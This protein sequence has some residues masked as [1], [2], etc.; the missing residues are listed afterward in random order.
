[1]IKHILKDLRL[2]QELSEDDLPG[3]QLADRLFK[4]VATLDNGNGSLQGTQAM[5]RAYQKANI[6]SV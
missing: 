1:M 5:I 6:K 2:V 4:L 3:V